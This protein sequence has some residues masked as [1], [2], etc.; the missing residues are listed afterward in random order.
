MAARAA[1]GETVAA[2]DGDALREYLPL[3]LT[4]LGTTLLLA[5]LVLI[6]AMPAALVV[7]L[8]RHLRIPVLAPLLRGYVET[9]R[10]LPA[11]IVLYLAFYG[12]P[13]LGVSLQPFP[14]AALGMALTSIA[15]VSE[16]FRASLATIAPGQWDAGLS[17]GMSRARIVRRIILP[18]ALP[19]MIPPVM[20]NAIITI[21]AT[22][23][24]SLVGVQ[25]LTGASVAAMSMTF[26]ATDFLVL[27]ALLYLAIAA[28]VLGVQAV[29]ELWVARRFGPRGG[30][31]NVRPG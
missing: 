2:M 27:A 1:L 7:A 13:R 10:A 29:A 18:Q 25:E 23:T 31:A 3:I 14:A 5:T 30:R 22:S 6:A 16:D 9:F 12:L 20:A 15:Y 8:C 26:S 24:A 11:L 19:V 21:K 17:L 4:G 28:V